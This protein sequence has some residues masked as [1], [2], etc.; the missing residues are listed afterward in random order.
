MRQ[1][2]AGQFKAKCLRVISEVQQTR[3]E[4]LITKHGKP[5]VKLVPVESDQAPSLLG[6]L[7]GT[8]QITGDIISPVDEVWEADI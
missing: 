2:A 5:V 1:M 7:Q 6:Y 8:V 3:E 4:V